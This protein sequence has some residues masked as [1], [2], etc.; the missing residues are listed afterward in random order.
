M[1]SGGALEGDLVAEGLE[2]ADVVTHLAVEVDSGVV[3]VGAQGV[4]LVVVG[5]LGNIRRHLPARRDRRGA[6]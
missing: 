1:G 6:A 3:V 5:H 2:L 4:E